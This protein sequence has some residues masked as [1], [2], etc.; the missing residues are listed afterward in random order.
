MILVIDKIIQLSRFFRVYASDASVEASGQ[1]VTKD[2]WYGFRGQIKWARDYTNSFTWLVVLFFFLVVGIGRVEAQNNG[3]SVHNT[4]RNTGNDGDPIVTGLSAALIGT[5]GDGWLRLTSNMGNQRGYAYID[6]PFTPPLGM[7]I[8]FAYRAWAPDGISNNIGIGLAD[9]I[10]V[11]L[12]DGATTFNPGS[13][14]GGLMYSRSYCG[15]VGGAVA[16]ALDG[17]YVGIGLDEYGNYSCKDAIASD[18]NGPGTDATRA[19]NYSS[20]IAIRGSSPNTAYIGGTNVNLKNAFDATLNGVAIG[21]TTAGNPPDVNKYYRQVRFY[22]L[23]TGSYPVQGQPDI[24]DNNVAADGT[25]DMLISVFIQTQTGGPFRTVIY[26]KRLNQR[27]R[28][29][30]TKTFKIG[31]GAST[32]GGYSNH[33]IRDMVAAAPMQL[34]TINTVT[35]GTTVVGGGVTY[36]TVIKNTGLH[37]VSTLSS[38]RATFVINTTGVDIINPQNIPLGAVINEGNTN[39]GNLVTTITYNAAASTPGNYVY[40]VSNFP[41]GASIV[42]KYNG[43]I[44]STAA[45]AINKTSIIPPNG[46]L[47]IDPNSGNSY[48][49]TFIQPVLTKPS[50]ITAACSGVALNK[51]FSSVPNDFTSYTWSRS[52]NANIGGPSNGA[53]TVLNDVL[54]NTSG[55]DQTITYSVTPQ[56]TAVV[57]NA[58]GSSNPNVTNTS[59]GNSQTFNVTLKST[60]GGANPDITV[61][62]FNDG[63]NLILTASSG[64]VSPT[65]TWYKDANKTG[66]SIGT[67]AQLT[68]PLNSKT[69][70]WQVGDSYTYFVTVSASGTCESIIVTKTITIPSSIQPITLTFTDIN[71]TPLNPSQVNGSAAGTPVYLRASLPPLYPAPAG[72]VTIIL[73]R[74]GTSTAVSGSDYNVNISPWQIVIPATKSSVTATVFLAKNVGVI[75]KSSQLTLDGVA[76][77]GYV[78]GSTPTIQINDTTGNA[79]GSITVTI[80]SGT[81]SETQAITLTASLPSGITT[82]N[83]LTVTITPAPGFLSGYSVNG[84]PVTAGTFNVVI[85]AG[86]GSISFVVKTVLNNSAANIVYALNGTATDGTRTFTVNSGTLT[87]TSSGLVLHVDNSVTPT[88]QVLG[89]AVTYT[90]VI[91]NIGV[92]DLNVGTGSATFSVNVSGVDLATDVNGIV[93]RSKRLGGTS[94]NYVSG[95]GGSYTYTVG[96]LPAGGSL[97]LTYVGTMS[98]T[99]SSGVNVGHILPP[100]PYVNNDVHRGYGAAQTFLMPVMIQPYDDHT[101]SGVALN[102]G[103]S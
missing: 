43:T 88:V 69:P 39:P 31:F 53:G 87:V 22:L 86:A 46:Y 28:V 56:I 3:F 45:S 7:S 26:N 68:V 13:C 102:K 65:F 38:G 63:A 6:K 52:A 40:T 25:V 27:I 101:C 48:A 79:P 23:P 57:V 41:V 50:D 89:G 90:T 62:S 10:S 11:Y 84:A 58:D 29:D 74:D 103:F 78:M 34:Q 49:Q 55:V 61:T 47:N 98:S 44:S 95:N 73:S 82:A 99:A 94:F 70:A 15:G 5:P 21:T 4:F 17:G 18:D 51:S 91:S 9:G 14:G 60:S 42:L 77:A 33:D 97:T 85:P 36:T 76:P 92:H 32:G 12:F 54:T 19:T 2:K 30:G 16:S 64:L 75:G 37:D 83:P 71:G 35:P 59:T 72:G 80:S 96:N 93:F 66:G 20:S 81:V 100:P 67:G 8:Q 1:T 24:P